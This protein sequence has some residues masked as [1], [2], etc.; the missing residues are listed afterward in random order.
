MGSSSVVLPVGV[1]QVMAL[2]DV[3]L[4]VGVQA[5]VTVEADIYDFNVATTVFAIHGGSGSHSTA[6]YTERPFTCQ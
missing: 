1:G 6:D 2:A 4:I 5:L 3:G